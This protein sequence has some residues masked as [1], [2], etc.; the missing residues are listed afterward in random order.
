MSASTGGKAE[1][2]REFLRR[3]GKGAAG[4]AVITASLATAKPSRAGIRLPYW[5]STW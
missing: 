2:R 5:V 1:R 4:A 3:A